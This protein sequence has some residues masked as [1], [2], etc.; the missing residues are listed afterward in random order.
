VQY[1]ARRPLPLGTEVDVHIELSRPYEVFERKGR[2]IW[3]QAG[4]GADR[5][6]VSVHFSDRNRDKMI[7]WRRM[8]SSRG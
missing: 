5:V 6:I 4:S 2:V 7:A 3:S 1:Y 8:L